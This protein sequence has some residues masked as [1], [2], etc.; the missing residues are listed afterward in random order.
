MKIDLKGIFEAVKNKHFSTGEFRKLVEDTSKERLEIC[1]ACPYNSK[2][3]PH[4]ASNLRFDEHCL[5]CGCNL[6]YKTKCLSCQ[7]PLSPPKWGPVM[8]DKEEKQLNE[9]VHGK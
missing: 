9:E 1:R 2:V 8:N 4:L 5:H 7:C 3:S 6:E